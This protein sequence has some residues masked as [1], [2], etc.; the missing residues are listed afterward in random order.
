[1][2]KLIPLLAF[3]ILLLVPVGAQNAFGPIAIP[4]LL[5]AR[6]GANESPPEGEGLLPLGTNFD[7]VLSRVTFAT[8]I[9]M[10]SVGQSNY[11][12]PGNPSD[13]VNG[14]SFPVDRFFDVFFEITIEDIDPINEGL[15]V[16]KFERVLTVTSTETC[17]ADTS[18]PNFG[19]IEQLRQL[20]IPS[21]DIPLV[22]DLDRDGNLDII[23]WDSFEFNNFCCP[24]IDTAPLGEY[25]ITTVYTAITPGNVN[26]SFSIPL[27][28]TIAISEEIFFP[29]IIGGEIIPLET[30]SLILAGAQT[31]SWMIPVVLSVLGIGLFVVSRKSENS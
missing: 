31:F 11:Q 17:V 24:M 28:G 21:F 25:K 14:Q 2:N 22:V 18:K 19:C 13:V 27:S 9:T 30:T 5:E 7:L 1:L 12:F 26:P 29:E 16:D 3:S 10:Q 20:S 23:N 6:I 15:S 4:N 8:S